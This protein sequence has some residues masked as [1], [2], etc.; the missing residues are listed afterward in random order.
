MSQLTLHKLH[1]LAE[2]RSAYFAELR[3]SGRWK[4]Y[5]S[6]AEIDAKVKESAGFTEYWRKAVESARIGD[7][8][9][10]A[11]PPVSLPPMVVLP[12]V[13]PAPLAKAG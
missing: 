4:H 5:F 12:R 2:Q 9:V 3:D 10:N 6:E 13:A 1:R 7:A 8:T 11:L